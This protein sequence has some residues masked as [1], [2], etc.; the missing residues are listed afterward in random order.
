MSPF[1]LRQF[2]DGRVQIRAL[3]GRRMLAELERNES[4][5]VTVL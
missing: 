1:L 3:V 4:L 5:K 2:E